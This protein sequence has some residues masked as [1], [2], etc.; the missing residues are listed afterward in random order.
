MPDSE[1]TKERTMGLFEATSLGV[2]AIVGGGILALAGVAFAT[3]GP[4]AILAFAINGL[5]AFLTALSFAQLATMFPQ[6]GGTYTYAKRILSV[7]TAFY[8]GWIVW[9]ASIAA[10]VLYSVGF[11]YFTAISV[12]ECWRMAFGQTPAWLT[13]RPF[14]VALGV[15]AIGFY[16]FHLIRKSGGGGAHWENI[17]KLTLFVVLI[18][19]GAYALMGRSTGTLSAGMTPFF[20]GGAL[21]LF[22]AMGFTFIA[23]QGFDL[24]A[25]AGGEIRN[26]TRTIPRAMYLS[27]GIALAIYLPL[28]FTIAAAGLEPG[29]SITSVSRDN[30]EEI[31]AIA[32]KQF[33]GVPGF[34]LVLVAAVLSMLSALRANMFAASRVAL[35]MA[36]DRTMPYQLTSIH[37][38]RGTPVAAILATA[39]IIATVVV[40]LPDVS[41]AGAVSSLIFLITFAAAHWIAILARRRRYAGLGPSHATWFPSLPTAGMICCVLLAVYQGIMVPSAGIVTA[42]WL[43]AGGLLFV[44]LFAHHARIVDASAEAQDPELLRLRGRTPLVLVPIANPSNA[45]AMMAVANALTPPRVGRVLL[46]SVAVSPKDVEAGDDVSAVRHAQTVL[47]D[48]LIA[49]LKIGIVPEALAT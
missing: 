4:S 37:R 25:A 39:I 38:V 20:S 6:S 22:Q 36:R 17:G 1:T 23:L 34:W 2:G 41:T 8:I 12:S 11:G 10:G 5:L 29:Q 26:P 24:I 40:V 16:A 48:S 43:G 21:G 7:E 33:L 32:A 15:G 46:L 14:V 30:P 27:L 44:W 13:S 18:V 49:S 28:L 9:F 31:V 3:S 35:A 19:A 47:G 45:E 42:I